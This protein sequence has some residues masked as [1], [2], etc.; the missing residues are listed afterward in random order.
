MKTNWPTPQEFYDITNFY[1]K[2]KSVYNFESQI[3][4][5]LPKVALPKDNSLL[6]PLINA[7]RKPR[8]AI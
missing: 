5:K 2:Y 1:F 3:F 8:I 7:N 6:T 4:R